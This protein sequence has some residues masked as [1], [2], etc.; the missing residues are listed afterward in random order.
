M[1]RKSKQRDPERVIEYPSA[2]ATYSHPAYGVYS[3]GE[4]PRS[5]VLAGRVRR[6]F[7]DSFPT[8]AEA[9]AAYPDA[10]VGAGCGFAPD[11]MLDLPDEDGRTY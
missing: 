7:L 9:Q 8:L 4:Y 1:A 6:V 10:T 5:S 3:Y 2:G 11:A